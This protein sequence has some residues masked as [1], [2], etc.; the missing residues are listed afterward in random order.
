MGTYLHIPVSIGFQPIDTL[1]ADCECISWRQ[2]WV[3]VI[4]L[5]GQTM[6]LAVVVAWNSSLHIGRHHA[7]SVSHS[8]IFTSLKSKRAK[9]CW[10]CAL[11]IYQTHH[12]YNS[13]SQPQQQRIC[14]DRGRKSDPAW[15]DLDELIPQVSTCTQGKMGRALQ[16]HGRALAALAI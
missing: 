12:E 14:T 3:A 8:T 7:R 9:F 6:K 10:S 2:L 11:W 13:A 15:D 5:V 1:T 16:Q 4:K